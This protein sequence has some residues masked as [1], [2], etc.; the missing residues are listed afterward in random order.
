[1]GSDLSKRFMN[2]LNRVEP[3][4]GC[5]V[6][7]MFIDEVG[8]DRASEILDLS[9]GMT[10]FK[11]YLTENESK[12]I[13]D[14]MVNYDD[15]KGAKWTPEE[16]KNVINSLG[17]KCEIDGQFNW[18]SLYTTIQMVHSDEWGVLR[19]VVEPTKEAAVCY[20]L[21]KAKLLDKDKIFNVRKYFEV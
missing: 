12:R 3:K 4:Y 5:M 15:S 18:W 20:E 9:E 2:I 13:V 1:M 7:D 19:N 21:A 16:L 14:G 10:R 8:E 11:N 17:G 6:I